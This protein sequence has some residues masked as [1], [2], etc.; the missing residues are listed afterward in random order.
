MYEK[1][2]KL[3]D[4]LSLTNNKDPV[5][6]AASVAL[7]DTLETSDSNRI[8][9]SRNFRHKFVSF[10][11]KTCFYYYK[12]TLHCSDRTCFQC[13][14]RDYQRLLSLYKP[15]LTSKSRLRF[16]TLT[17]RYRTGVLPQARIIRIRKS[18][19]KLFSLYRATM[20]GGFYSIEAKQTS[21][22]WNVHIHILYEGAYIPQP[23]IKSDWLNITGDSYI[24]FV[25]ATKPELGGSLGGFRYILKYLIKEPTDG[26]YAQNAIYNKAFKGTRLL[27]AFGTWYKET[28]IKIPRLVCPKC[29]DTN[30]LIIVERQSFDYSFFTLEADSSPPQNDR[31]TKLVSTTN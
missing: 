31:D 2:N 21:R 18:F 20:L 23:T 12:T 24:V 14:K 19:K 3:T 10:V 9:S 16:L 17:L 28:K 29:G 13:R 15:F 25:E 11:C 8:L 6:G 5:K 27:S 7:L 4:N 22:G 26:S 1:Y 30:W